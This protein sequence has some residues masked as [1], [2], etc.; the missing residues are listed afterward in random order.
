MCWAE[1]SLELSRQKNRNCRKS[2]HDRYCFTSKTIGRRKP[3][4]VRSEFVNGL[5]GKKLG[6]TTFSQSR[7]SP[8]QIDEPKCSTDSRVV[9]KVKS[10]V[11]ID[12]SME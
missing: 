11:G 12:G 4:C 1:V 5:L 7:T 8:T 2:S 9:T 10:S 3:V 6:L